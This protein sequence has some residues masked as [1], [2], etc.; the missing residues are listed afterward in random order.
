MDYR[1][2]LFEK[3]LLPATDIITRTVV[4]WSHVVVRNWKSNVCSCLCAEGIWENG[5]IDPVTVNLST[6]LG[7]MV[8]C[9]LTKLS[10]R[11]WR[12]RTSFGEQNIFDPWKESNHVSSVELIHDTD[13]YAILTEVHHNHHNNNNYHLLLLLLLLLLKPYRLLWT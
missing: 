11:L 10:M 7:R 13:Y 12:G 1:K 9:R 2:P 6:V 5:S 4:F 8:R 3:F